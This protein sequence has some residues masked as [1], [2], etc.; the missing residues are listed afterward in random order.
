MDMQ[1]RH[2]RKYILSP[3][4]AELLRRRISAVMLP[5]S[6]SGG[7]Y[8]VHNLY[9]DDQYDS[10]Y[11]EKLSGAMVRDKYR[12]R[13][14]NGDLS[15]IRMERKHKNGDLSYKQS[16]VLTEG[17]Y[18][19]LLAGRVDFAPD[20]PD[21]L[22]REIGNL[23]RLRALRPAAVFSYQREAYVYAPGNVRVTFDSR[24]GTD[25]IAGAGDSLIMELKYDQFLPDVI[26][27]LLNGIPIARTEMSKY[28]YVRGKTW[29]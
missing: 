15:F 16:A 24:I 2:E 3:R 8:T 27:V 23:H 5:D 12:A 18:A 29:I 21:P 20:E 17:Q 28:G 9:L 13:F 6:H 19:S 11:R 26:A 4:S 10:F 22:L 25:E 1:Y 7:M 14:Y